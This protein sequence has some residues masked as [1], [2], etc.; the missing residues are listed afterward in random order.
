MLLTPIDVLLTPAATVKFTTATTPF[1]IM[2]AFIPV[3]WQVYLP[4]PAEQY[5]LLLALV[6]AAPAL[7]EIETTSL[8]G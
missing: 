5:R 7:A 8:G 4:E 1:P 6:D 2:F 3:T